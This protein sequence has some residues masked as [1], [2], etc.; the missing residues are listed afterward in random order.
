MS[1][2]LVAILHS[3][4]LGA[5][6]RTLARVDVARRMLGLDTYSVANLYPEP[7][8]S[9]GCVADDAAVWSAG[10]RD[11]EREL[12]RTDSTDVLLGYG[13]SL[14]SGPARALHRSQV[15]WLEAHLSTSGVRVWTF[16]GRPNHP[17]RWQRVAYRHR[18]GATVEETAPELLEPRSAQN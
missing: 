2:N 6:A 12:A 17:S 3:L 9:S 13:V 11:V 4:P 10:R 15:R 7:L 16:G 18:P 1:S 5:G 8:A 14:P